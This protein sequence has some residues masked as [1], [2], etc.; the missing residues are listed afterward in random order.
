MKADV[1]TATVA[2]RMPSKVRN[3]A[4]FL[5]TIVFVGLFSFLSGG[6]ILTRSA[7]VAILYLLCAVWLRFLRRRSR[8]GTLYLLALAV[9]GIFVAWA[10]FSVLWSFGP[11]L[12]WVAFDIAALYL[13]AV[14]VLGFTPVARCS[15]AFRC[16]GCWPS[17]L[18][19]LYTPIWARS[20]RIS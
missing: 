7:P 5:L 13:A 1:N 8:P 2:R 12:S 14:A 16:T 15:F 4:P 9:F 17:S 10:G 6:Y 11:D 20:S 3:V 19:L 18:P